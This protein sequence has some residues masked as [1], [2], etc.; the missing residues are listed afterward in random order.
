MKK[1]LIVIIILVVILAAAVFGAFLF[2][3]SIA[4]TAIERGGT[5]ALG[6]PTTLRTAD[7]GVLSGTFEMQG[8]KVANPQGFPSDHFLSLGDAGVAVSLG[9]LQKDT[10]Q[11][12]ELRFE[13]MDVRLEKKDG[14]T[15][16]KVILDN[17]KKLS[18][19]GKG[20]KPADK[21]KEG[22]KKFVI[23]EFVLRNVTVHYDAIGGGIAK[24]E[25]PIDEI[26]LHN[27]GQTGS[28]VAGSGV[29]MGELAGLVV[30]AVLAAAVKNGGGLLPKDVLGDLEGQLAA[31]GDLGGSLSEMGMNVVGEA[32]KVAEDIGKEAEKAAEEGKKAV[33]DLGKGLKDLLPGGV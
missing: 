30:K 7:V 23:Q 5:Y 4:R 14:A 11:L 10:V 6:V 25:I 27:V 1:I 8:L 29:S 21:P 15:N 31:L 3:D 24:V 2:V 18:G 26:R 32:G 12:P 17:L 19:D 22:G 28:G 13:D 9:T 16:Y 20:D 33:E